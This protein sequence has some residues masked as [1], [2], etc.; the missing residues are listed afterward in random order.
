MGIK[1]GMD[2]GHYGNIMWNA[3]GNKIL[4]KKSFYCEN[5]ANPVE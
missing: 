5:I 1:C 3:C 2:M 4:F